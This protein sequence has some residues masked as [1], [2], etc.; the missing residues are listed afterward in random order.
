MKKKYAASSNKPSFAAII[1]KFEKFRE[2]KIIK[3]TSNNPQATYT[4][5]HKKVRT[6]CAFSTGIP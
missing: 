4:G 1:I 2:D 3:L 5:G 6:N